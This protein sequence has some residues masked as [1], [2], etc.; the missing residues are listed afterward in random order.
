VAMLSGGFFEFPVR[1]PCS[2][3]TPVPHHSVPLR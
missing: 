3:V 2:R 1:R